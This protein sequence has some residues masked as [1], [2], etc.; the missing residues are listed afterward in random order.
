MRLLPTVALLV[1]SCACSTG[2]QGEVHHELDFEPVA[3]ELKGDGV[4]DVFR[5]DHIVADDVFFERDAFSASEVQSFLEV[6]PYDSKRSFLADERMANGQSFS[7]ALVAVAKSHNL[8]PLVLLVTLQKE[9]GLVS[10]TV[11]PRGDRVDFAFGCGCPDGQNCSNAFRGLDKQLAC[12]AERMA[13]YDSNLVLGEPTIAGWKPGKFKRTSE[14]INLNPAN[15]STAIL[16]T[17]TPWVLEGSGGNWLFWN[18]WRRYSTHLGYSDGLT[19][20][21]NEG[22]IGAACS[23]DLDCYFTG[24][25]CDMNSL[26]QGVCTQSCD[27]TC[28]DRPGAHWTTTFC[29]AGDDGGTCV[30]QCGDG[31]TCAP[32]QLC[33]TRSRNGEVDVTRQVCTLR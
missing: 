11:R 18:V 27:R 1:L 25:R 15:R 12:S 21:F 7:S 6:T 13:S 28:P 5:R 4:F 20:P 32:G 3:S 33:R 22:Y 8:N 17:Y 23:S 29:I 2:L 10:R 24:A 19:Y 26:G 16:Y 9:A 14:G 31:G 30:A